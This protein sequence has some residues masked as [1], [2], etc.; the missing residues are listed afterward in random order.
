M[1][2]D[3][4]SFARASTLIH[5]LQGLALLVLG[6]CEA[7]SADNPG[8]RIAAAGPLAL[9]AA[10][11]G[12]P[13]VVFLLPGGGSVEQARVAL[14]LRRGFYLFV[15]FSCLFGAAGLSRLAGIA[16]GREKGGWEGLFLAFLALSGGLYF[17]MASRVNEEAWRQVM[18]WHSAMG[19]TLLLAVAAGAAALLSGR[20]VFRVGWAA[21]LLATSIQL[22]TY[23]EADSAF[24]VK[25][26]TIQAS[27]EPLPAQAA[28]A[29]PAKPAKKNAATADKERPRR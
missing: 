13:L 7:Y 27:Q 3:Y 23:R 25:M 19:A 18:V 21:L 16:S 20:R 11:V 24:S 28:P 2:L 1:T 8:R 29:K 26:V 17:M 22:L 10:A 12:I 5:S 15:A 14:E 9:L 6:A 4:A